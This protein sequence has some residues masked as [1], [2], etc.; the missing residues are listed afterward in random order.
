MSKPETMMIDDVKYIREDAVKDNTEHTNTDGLPM[1]AVRSATASPFFGYLV[2]HQDKQAELLEGRRIREWHG[3][4]DLSQM[5][6]EGVTEPNKCKFGVACH[7]TVD[8]VSEVI[9]CT[10]TATKILQG[11]KEWKA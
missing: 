3:A 5:A 1:V 8:N 11:V 2:K 4:M 10:E 6:V 7:I 9:R